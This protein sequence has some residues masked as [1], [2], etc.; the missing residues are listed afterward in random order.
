[1]GAGIEQLGNSKFS[2]ARKAPVNHLPGRL[3]NKMGP[4]VVGE[5]FGFQNFILK[6]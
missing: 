4:D 1:M 3:W 2:A 6:I 5:L